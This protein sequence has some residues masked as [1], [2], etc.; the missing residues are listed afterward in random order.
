MR[1][2]AAPTGAADR[3]M[4]RVIP[5]FRGMKLTVDI[6]ATGRT[7]ATMLLTQGR[8]DALRGESGSTGSLAKA[9]VSAGTIG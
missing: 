7:T 4:L 9:V 5:M 6:I 1:R 8:V 2:V 3:R